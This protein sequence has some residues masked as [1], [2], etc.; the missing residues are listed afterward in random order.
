MKYKITID[1]ECSASLKAVHLQKVK[2]MVEETVI[3][4]LA[5]PEGEVMFVNTKLTNESK[6]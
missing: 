6:K 3:E 2:S 5:I 1:I 4:N